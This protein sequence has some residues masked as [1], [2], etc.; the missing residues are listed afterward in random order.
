MAE[1]RNTE[2]IQ[3]IALAVIFIGLLAFSIPLICTQ[4]IPKAN[5]HIFEAPGRSVLNIDKAGQ[6]IV[7]REKFLQDEKSV[8]EAETR[9]ALKLEF[10]IVPAD[11]P[12]ADPLELTSA[13]N[14]YVYRSG[15]RKGISMFSFESPGPGTYILRAYYPKGVG[16]Q[17][18]MSLGE[19]SIN[20]AAMR[21]T[22][23]SIILGVNVC[24]VVVVLLLVRKM[25]QG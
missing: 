7:Y 23:V 4:L 3:I 21:R 12:R 10:T 25:L 20:S 1:N 2:K 9:A 5:V 17:I 15:H 19:S 22:I 14:E 6:Y 18:R 16:P 24:L 8:Q 11:N 13:Q